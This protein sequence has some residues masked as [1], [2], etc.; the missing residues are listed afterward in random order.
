M[1]VCLN[2]IAGLSSELKLSGGGCGLGGACGDIKALE[3]HI[4]Q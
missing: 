3:V 1:I 4:K 2:T